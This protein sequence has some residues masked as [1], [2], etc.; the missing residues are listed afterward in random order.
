MKKKKV[1]PITISSGDAQ[2]ETKVLKEQYIGNQVGIDQEG[3]DVV[4][5]LIA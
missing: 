1:A 3:H 5:R 4:V 2:E